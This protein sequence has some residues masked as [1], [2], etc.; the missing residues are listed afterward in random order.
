[1]Y[2][3]FNYVPPRQEI[4]ELEQRTKSRYIRKTSSIKPVKLDGKKYCAW[5]GKFE[6]FGRCVKYCSTGCKESSDLFSNP[7][8]KFALVFFLERQEFKCTL[9]GYDYLPIVEE[10]LKKSVER[11]KYY[12]YETCRYSIGYQLGIKCK[13]ETKPE[14]DHEIA[15]CNGGA[16]IG[17]GNHRVICNKC[18]T[19]K[20]KED[21]RIAQ[22]G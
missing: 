12:T 17:I 13:G 9:C 1:M 10:I 2:K 11:Y 6:I 18:H 15:I 20:T 8:S 4:K 22:F 14:I 3:L 7:Q 5:C 21:R 19:I 16:S